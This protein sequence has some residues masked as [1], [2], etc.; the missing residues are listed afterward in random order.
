MLWRRKQSNFRKQKNICENSKST[1]FFK[2]C[3]WF[4]RVKKI[5]QNR[6]K[7]E[8]KLRKT[9]WK[10]IHCMHEYKSLQNM[11]QCLN[12]DIKQALRAIH[13]K[14]VRNITRK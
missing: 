9:T 1:F 5:R 10:L 12:D 2:F 11:P 6:N 4:A 13:L 8:L 14:N 7:Y 3:I